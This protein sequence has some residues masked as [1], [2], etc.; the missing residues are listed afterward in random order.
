L[1]EN[2]EKANEKAYGRGK[3]FLLLT[4]SAHVVWEASE[5]FKTILEGRTWKIE[6]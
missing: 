1:R 4:L 2:L 3:P 5:R 6:V